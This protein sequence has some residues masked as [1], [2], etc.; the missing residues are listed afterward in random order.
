[1]KLDRQK[2]IYLLKALRAGRIDTDTL[3]RWAENDDWRDDF[4]FPPLTVA[5]VV[6]AARLSGIALQDVIKECERLLSGERQD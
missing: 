6:E 4:E 3:R 2:R 5:D 1:M